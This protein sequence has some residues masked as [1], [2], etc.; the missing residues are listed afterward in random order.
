[1]YKYCDVVE[2][3]GGGSKKNNSRGVKVVVANEKA[4]MIRQGKKNKRTKA[5]REWTRFSSAHSRRVTVDI[6]RS[7]R[8][9]VNTGLLVVP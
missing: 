3:E 8:M 9:N 1:M 2:V 7:R 6:L 4:K 5:L